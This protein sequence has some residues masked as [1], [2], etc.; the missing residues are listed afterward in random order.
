MTLCRTC[1]DTPKLYEKKFSTM[2]GI[3]K[4][5]GVD[6]FDIRRVATVASGEAVAEP[7]PIDWI[8]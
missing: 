1:S 5:V 8:Y 6:E 3:M 2:K 4:G 7:L